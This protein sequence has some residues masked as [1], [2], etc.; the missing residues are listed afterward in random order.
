MATTGAPVRVARLLRLSPLPGKVA[1][2]AAAGNM[3]LDA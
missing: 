2:F 1:I 3:A